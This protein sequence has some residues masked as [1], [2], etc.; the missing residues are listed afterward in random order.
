[1]APM[2]NRVKLWRLF[3][4][5][6]IE[7][8]EF[9]FDVKYSVLCVADKPKEVGVSCV[10]DETEEVGE[11]CVTDKTEEVGVPYITVKTEEVSVPCVTDENGPIG[12]ASDTDG[13]KED[14]SCA[15]VKTEEDSHS[16]LI[17]LWRARK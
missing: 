15:T 2:T 16:L 12:E 8:S 17:V 13:I 9:A 4:G 10:T 3:Y 5:I 11:P 7:T 14:N 1:M 6:T